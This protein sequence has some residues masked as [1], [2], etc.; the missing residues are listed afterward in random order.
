MY[1]ANDASMVFRLLT[2]VIVVGAIVS[3]THF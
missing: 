2:K 1:H 3:K